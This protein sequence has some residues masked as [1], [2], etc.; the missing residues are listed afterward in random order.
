MVKYDKCYG[1][2]GRHIEILGYKFIVTGIYDNVLGLCKIE[3]RGRIQLKVMYWW[4]YYIFP[5][6]TIKDLMRFLF[7]MKRSGV[8]GVI[9]D[10]KTVTPVTVCPYCKAKQRIVYELQKC[11]F[12]GKRF[13]VI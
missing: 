6:I 11:I 10:N 13:F 3:P 4:D 1:C 2:V 12:C 7:R 5:L 9:C 8:M